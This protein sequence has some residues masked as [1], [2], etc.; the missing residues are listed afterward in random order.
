VRL[1]DSLD[2]GLYGCP[3]RRLFLDP[4]IP[5]TQEESFK[6]FL[7]EAFAVMGVALDPVRGS[8]FEEETPGLSDFSPDPCDRA[9]PV[10]E[11]EGAE[12]LHHL[13]EELAN[14]SR[15]EG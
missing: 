6:A 7:G 5:T 13:L 14:M 1:L 4:S 3:C 9:S 10:D 2:L 12:L 15:G 11:K 8:G